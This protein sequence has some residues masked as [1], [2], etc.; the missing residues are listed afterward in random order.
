[1]DLQMKL[2]NMLNEE[3]F[4]TEGKSD[5]SKG[6][7][8]LVF[9]NINNWNNIIGIIKES[10]IYNDETDDYGLE[11][12]PHATVIYGINS[13]IKHDKIRK[14][15]N[16]NVKEPLK[17]TL[18]GISVFEN[19]KYDVV[20]FNV[21]SPDLK[22]LHALVKDNFDN[23]LTFKDYIPHVTIGY[24]HKGRGKDYIFNL[25]NKIEIKSNEFNYSIGSSDFIEFKI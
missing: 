16:E 21:E 15:I 13:T 25:K 18:T 20:K 9:K 4:L 11:N 3:E 10:D 5:T 12:K 22:A 8:M 6:C 24:V 2:L 19:D 17:I 23:E 7:L 1:M 14:F